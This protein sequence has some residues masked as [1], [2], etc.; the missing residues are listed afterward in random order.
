MASL[1]NELTSSPIVTIRLNPPVLDH[2]P[3]QHSLVMSMSSSFFR[4]SSQRLAAAVVNSGSKSGGGGSGSQSKL[5]EAAAAQLLPPLPLYR[6]LLRVHRKVLPIEMR[7]MGDEYI[8][9]Q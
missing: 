7:V 3:V 6:R 5:A 4:G 8:K 9:V 2:P 1:Y